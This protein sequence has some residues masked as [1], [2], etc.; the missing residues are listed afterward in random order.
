MFHLLLSRR[1]WLAL[2]AVLA[3]SVITARAQEAL[4]VPDW[5]NKKVL[6]FDAY[7]GHLLD[8]NFI[9]GAPTLSQPLAAIPSG[10]G[11]I[12]I[13]DNLTKGIFEYNLDGTL[14]RTLSDTAMVGGGAV[15]G[16]DIH[17]N[18][19]YAV[20][21]SGTYAGTVQKFDL[22]TGDRIGTFISG[23]TGP[24]D[25][26]FRGGDALIGE[27]YSASLSKITQWSLTG[28]KIADWVTSD[29]VT[30]I[31]LPYQIT[32]GNGD[33]ILVGGF[34]QPAGVYEYDA[35]GGLVTVWGADTGRF[36]R[37][38]VVLGNGNMFYT[39]NNF[40]TV[41]DKNTGA[42][43]DLLT[44]GNFQMIHRVNLTAIPEPG[45]LSLLALG[46][47]ALPWRRRRS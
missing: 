41:I 13:G 19:L 39:A 9:A 26:Y 15:K 2:A 35:N 7:D 44:S 5:A 29:G 6:S 12:L 3:V 36:F 38:G 46:L 18:E 31:D 11:T 1:G 25:I 42:A 40:V 16:L 27:R 10:N 43:T 30:G 45:T 28:I 21:T 23:L 34:A 8:A 22:N 37:G 33:H 4:L 14:K 24:T 20:I 32:G 17:Q 47:A